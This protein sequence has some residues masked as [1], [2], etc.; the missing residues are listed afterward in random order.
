MHGFCHF[1]ISTSMYAFHL[2][3]TLRSGNATFT[4]QE[5]NLLS[6][7]YWNTHPIN[8][9]LLRNPLKHI[10]EI[11]IKPKNSNPEFML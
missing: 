9:E 8:G 3:W 1:F 6:A 4:L 5:V 11:I 10:Q 7:P 2:E